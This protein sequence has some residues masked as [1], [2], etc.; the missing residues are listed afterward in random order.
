MSTASVSGGT[1]AGKKP[2]VIVLAV[3]GVVAIIVGVLYMVAGSS[4]PSFLTAGSH[5]HK[6]NHLAR[7]GV[8][9]VVGIAA[10]IGA[11]F[12]TKSKSK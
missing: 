1:S 10:F 2:L 3:I 8:L 6:G 11:W 12:S 5:V 7:G 4:L 9:L